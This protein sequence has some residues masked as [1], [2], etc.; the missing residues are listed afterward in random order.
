MTK[1]TLTLGSLF[2]GSGGFPLAGTLLG[3]EP[4]WASEIEPFPIRVTTKRFP[5]M[6]HYGDV[7]KIN[8]ALIDPVDVIT[9]GSPCQDLSSNGKR[10]G[11]ENGERSHLF[12]EAIRIIKEMRQT[13]HN[14]YP[15]FLVWENVPGAFTSNR[16][17]DF[18]SV[19]ES[20]VGI[21]DGTITIPRSKG[22]QKAG[23]ILGDDFTLCWRVLDSQYWRTAQRRRR[24]FVTVDLDRRSPE[25]LF[26][27]QNFHW[28]FEPLTGER[29]RI[30]G[31]SE[32]SV[33]T[34]SRATVLGDTYSFDPQ[35]WRDCGAYVLKDVSNP[36]KVCTRQAVA[37][38]TPGGYVARRFSATECARLQGF[39]DWWCAGLETATPTDEEVE[40]WQSI[41]D[42]WCD[43]NNLK[44]KTTEHVKRWLTD[45]YTESAEYKLWGNGVA[46][47][48]VHF[49]LAGFVEIMKEEEK[50]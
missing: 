33:A 36:L 16:G 3:I 13:T 26:E 17:E 11:L 47:P 42:N 41:W 50:E 21:K 5:Q 4:K 19:L 32:A 35:A 9:F 8:G 48:C 23:R 30:A 15:R 31:V 22:W 49:V 46:L 28:D 12:Y 1:H 2:D 7:S 14:R 27:S 18:H 24:L 39:P 44:R 38:E 45:P 37:Y 20:L 43:I 25:M 6:K 34:P 10:A 40:R 29:Q